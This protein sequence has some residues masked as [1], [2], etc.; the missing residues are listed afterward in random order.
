MNAQAL[1]LKSFKLFFFAVCFVAGLTGCEKEDVGS[2]VVT[3]PLTQQPNPVP[4]NALV[5]QLRQSEIDYSAFTYD[6]KNR[7]VQ[8]RSQWQYMPGDPSAIRTIDY[9]YQYDAQNRPTQLSYTQ[10]FLTRFTHNNLLVE[11]AQEFYPGGAIANDYTYV[12]AQ[13]RI[14]QMLVKN[15]DDLGEPP[16]NYKYELSYDSIGNLNKIAIYEERSST[17]GG[18][19]YVLLETKEFSDFDNK[20]NPIGWMMQFPYL[21]TI[22]WQFNNPG[23]EVIKPTG[24]PFTTRI[25]TY[26]YND[27]GLP[28]TR[29][30]TEG[31]SSATIQY[32]Y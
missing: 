32:I 9:N 3:P 18:A 2:P 30:R 19:Q 26:T 13:G 28:I 31:G 24:G 14:I 1:K 17:P 8:L 16:T 23:K 10:G 29:T 20:V 25:Y 5:K 27:Q 12:Y 6:S 7:L 22:R 4:L 21:P 15:Y 11:K